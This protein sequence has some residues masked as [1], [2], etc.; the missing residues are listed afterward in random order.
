[1][2]MTPSEF[3]TR[4]PEFSTETDARVQ[5][6]IT[7]ADP[8]FDVARWDS[9]YS[10]G[11]ANYVAHFL[12]VAN[13][14]AAAGAAGKMLDTKLSKKV[15]DLAV[16][17]SEIALSARMKDPFMATPYGIEYRRL[18]RIVGMGALSV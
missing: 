2:T 1:M 6:F 9:L 13:A 12:T 18:A 10:L 8:M 4:F 5:L 15:G 3:K 17:N 14:Q 7:D 16:T 11:V